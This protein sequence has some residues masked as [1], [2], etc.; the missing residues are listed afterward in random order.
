MI[1]EN[2]GKKQANIKYTEVING[3]K[4]E[5]H[6]CEE[7]SQKLGIDE[8]DFSMPSL[9]FSSFFGDLINE[10]GES[11]FLPNFIQEK[12]LKCKK[13]GMTFEEFTNTGKFG[14][15]ECYK[16]FSKKIDSI[17]KNIHGDNKHIG[18]IGQINETN[19]NNTKVNIN[20]QTNSKL[21]NLREKLKQLVKEEKYEEAAKIRDEIKKEE[22]RE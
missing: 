19:E 8:I 18:S 10:Y 7:C 12:E 21:D 20:I 2:C 5:M 14:C 22:G 1:C 6:L 17:L 9:D 13:C 15:D 3:K 4:T 16:T 11:E